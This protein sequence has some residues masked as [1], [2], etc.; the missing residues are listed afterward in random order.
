[1]SFLRNK[2]K[3][4]A[5]S[6]ETCEELPRS[7]LAQNSNAPRSQKHYTIQ[8]FEVIESGVSK[9]LSQEFKR[10]E[11]R[12]LGALSRLD[13]FLM[14]P[15]IKGHSGTAPETSRFAYGINQVT[16][17]NEYQSDPHPEAGISPSQTTRNSRPEDAHDMVTGV[18][19]EITYCSSIT[20]SGKQKKKHSTSQPQFGSENTLATIEADQILLVL[21]QLANN[22]TFANVHGNI[23][24]I[25][26]LPKLF[27]TT[28]LHLTRN[29]RSLI[30]LKTFTKSTSKFAIN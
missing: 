20:S 5:L 17:E 18:R 14:N 13:D 7:N 23:N 25:F 10:T 28:S 9:K 8:V 1:M 6:E 19:D 11:S 4:A 29:L 26:N 21:Q 16:F 27:T 12:I 2:R 15:L 22:N 24:R 30:F 3:L